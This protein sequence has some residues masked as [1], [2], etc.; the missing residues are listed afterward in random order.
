MSPLDTIRSIG[1]PLA[2]Y[3]AM[4]KHVGGVN[5]AIFLGQLMYWDERTEDKLGVYKSSE[6]WEAETG[7][8]YKEQVNVRKKLKALGLLI[9]TNRR[10][11]H[12]I[13]FKLDHDAFNELMKQITVDEPAANK[14]DSNTEEDGET[15][16]GN[17]P[18]EPKGDS[19]IDQ[20]SFREQPNGS[21]PT[22]PNGNS[23]IDTE[24]TAETTTENILGDESPDED[25]LR[26]YLETS[27][28]KHTRENAISLIGL[29]Q[30]SAKPK[31]PENLLTLL[32]A[33]DRFW[34]A[35]LVKRSR[36]T[37]VPAFVKQLRVLQM[38][39]DDFVDM[40]VADIAA[41]KTAQQI[42][43]DQ[44]HPTTYLNE[45]RW[46]DELLTTTNQTQGAKHGNFASQDYHAGVTDDGSF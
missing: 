28:A 9:E 6:Q 5:A 10:L 24:T 42:G 22:D 23:L 30:K 1:R 33:F 2:Y 41:R 3:P 44:L 19:P 36:A 12:R 37:A 43:I 39:P 16:K 8:T 46:T 21:V 32:L 25:F 20:R 14:T 17:S 31:K 11:E 15:P 27:L 45:Q 26:S 7:L 29:M 34:C 18:K 38:R 35:G 40:V 13:Y 4:A